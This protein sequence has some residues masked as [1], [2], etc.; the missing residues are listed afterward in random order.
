MV[1]PI[2]CILLVLSGCAMK[3]SPLTVKERNRQIFQDLAVQFSHQKNPQEPITLHSAMA[4]AIHFNLSHRVKTMNQVLAQGMTRV[5]SQ[6]MLPRL[7][8]DAGYSTQNRLSSDTGQLSTSTGDLSISWNILDFGISYINAKQQA[9]RISIAKEIQRKAAHSLIQEVRATF[10]RAIAAKRLERAIA[11]LKIKLNAA[12]ASSQQAEEERIESPVEALNYQVGLLETLQKLQR[13]QKEVSNAGIKLAEL[14]G[15]DPGSPYTLVEQQESNPINLDQLPAIETLEGYAL[16]HRPELWEKDYRRRIKAYDTKKSILRLFPGLD[17]S[18]SGEYDSTKTYANNM[19]SEF[20]ISL[21]WNLINLIKA[22]DTIALSKDKEKMVD[23]SRLALNM[24]V[25]VQV[26]I[27]LRELM[28]SHEAHAI[29]TK[30]SVAKERLYQHAQAQQEAQTVNELELIS[31]E[32][33]RIL[34][35]SHRDLA[36]AKLQNALGAFL[37]SLGWD[38]IPENMDSLDFQQLTSRIEVSNGL[39]TT[40]EIPGFSNAYNMFNGLPRQKKPTTPQPED[41]ELD[42][43]EWTIEPGNSSSLLDQQKPLQAILWKSPKK[44]KNIPLNSREETALKTKIS[45]FSNQLKTVPLVSFNHPLP[46][47]KTDL[48]VFYYPLR[49]EENH[50]AQFPL[51]TSREH[52]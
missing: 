26:H 33:D 45:D 3:P 40:G 20:G 7:T 27:A 29:A 4:G 10:W 23:F 28:E 12:L 35:L 52:D 41:P 38:I 9:D 14:M 17:F 6:Q 47:K 48:E 30:L 22:P 32:G 42:S 46:Y 1:L 50:L 25:M 11:P 5:A 51:S 36:F 37:V 15:L 16:L 24:S 34:F 8:M 44:L 13:L 39:I 19:W 43:P 21:T 31:K 2:A 18:Q 49:L